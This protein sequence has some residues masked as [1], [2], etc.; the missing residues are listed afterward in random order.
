MD[1]AAFPEFRGARPLPTCS[2][3]LFG[4]QRNDQAARLMT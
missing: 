4:N 2:D 1:A 3:T